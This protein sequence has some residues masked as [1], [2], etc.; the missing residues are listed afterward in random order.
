MQRARMVRLAVGASILLLVLYVVLPQIGVFR[1]SFATFWHGDRGLLL[2]AFGAVLGTYLAA[3]LSYFVLSFR[4][5]MFRQVLLVQLSGAFINRLLP[6]GIGGIGLNAYYLRRQGHAGAAAAAVV[7]MNGVVGVVAHLILLLVVALVSGVGLVVR[8]DG[9]WLWWIVAGLVVLVALGG[10]AK[11]LWR[12]AVVARQ[13]R[14][15]YYA[16]GRFGHRRGALVWAFVAA[17]ALTCCNVLALW[18]TAWALG[19]E[20]SLAAALMLFTVGTAAATLTPTPGGVVGAEAALTAAIVATGTSASDA[21]SVALTFR[22]L[23]YWLPM[24]LGV[25]ATILA[26]RLRCL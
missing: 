18:L 15:F 17:L 13:M 10:F 24:V 6:A 9:M 2:L 26:R 14:Q 21:L 1:S 22:F 20:L 8:L 12:Y 19:V 16:V 5:L 4:R 3:A 7:T 23:T 11:R 25:A